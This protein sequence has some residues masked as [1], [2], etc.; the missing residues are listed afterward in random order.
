MLSVGLSCH[1]PQGSG[2]IVV[3][4]DSVLDGSRL[5]VMSR[6]AGGQQIN[7]LTTNGG[8]AWSLPFTNVTLRLDAIAGDP[9]AGVLWTAAYVTSDNYEW[10]VPLQESDGHV[11][12]INPLT[13]VSGHVDG[14]SGMTV[15]NGLLYVH[16][17]PADGVVAVRP[18]NGGAVAWRASSEGKGP[19]S[20]E[21]H[22]ALGSVGS[23]DEPLG[24]GQP[25]VRDRR[26]PTLVIRT[27]GNGSVAAAANLGQNL[28]SATPSGGHVYVTGT[29]TLFALKPRSGS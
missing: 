22:V 13:S 26:Q 2:R 11:G 8:V 16:Y 17:G 14:S 12:P 7:A 27:V 25:R 29:T 4:G 6:S 15:A 20:P 23:W 19:V 5:F 10:F 9:G 21:R 3:F 1:R 18:G 24:R 28:T